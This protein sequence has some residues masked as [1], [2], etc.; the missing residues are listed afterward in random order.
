MSSTTLLVSLEGISLG[1]VE[2]IVQA[3]GID[4]VIVV[5]TGTQ[6][7]DFSSTSTLNNVVAV[8]DAG[9]KVELSVN[10]GSTLSISEEAAEIINTNGFTFVNETS[11]SSFY[12]SLIGT[13]SLISQ[14]ANA[15]FPIF[16][17]DSTEA[18]LTLDSSVIIGEPADDLT[19]TTTYAG[20]RPTYLTDFG[21]TVT[22]NL[23]ADQFS[24]L[25]EETPEVFSTLTSTSSIDVAP[26]ELEPVLPNVPEAFNYLLD[27][28]DVPEN[29]KPFFGNIL[30]VDPTQDT[31][32]PSFDFAFYWSESASFNTL[33]ALS[34]PLQ[35]VLPGAIETPDGVTLSDTAENLIIALPQLSEGQLESFTKILVEGSSPLTLDVE[36]FAKLDTIFFPRNGTSHSGTNLVNA[37]GTDVEINLISNGLSD[38]FDAGLIDEASGE[39]SSSI[40]GSTG[41][42]LIQYIDTLTINNV[43]SDDIATLVELNSIAEFSTDDVVVNFTDHT[44]TADEFIALVGL[45]VDFSNNVSISDAEENLESLLLT[46][47]SDVISAFSYISGLGDPSEPAAL[48]ITYDQYLTLLDGDLDSTIFGN[49]INVELIVS[50]TADELASVFTALGTDFSSL[51]ENVSFRVTDGGEVTLNVAQADKL[52]GRYNG[53]ILISDIGDNISPMLLEAIDTSIKDISVSSGSLQLSVDEFRNLPAYNNDSVTIEDTESNIQ[54]A[55]TYNVLDDRVTKLNVVSES[56]TDPVTVLTLTAAQLENLGDYS[57]E[58]DDIA[59][60]SVVLN[61]RSSAIQEF[62]E[63]GNIPTNVSISFAESSSTDSDIRKVDLNFS[64]S[65]AL[66]HLIIDGKASVPGIEYNAISE[67]FTGLNSNNYFSF[68]SEST[69]S[70]IT[71]IIETVNDIGSNVLYNNYKLDV[72]ENRVEDISYITYE[73]RNTVNDIEDDVANL[74]SDVVALKETEIA[75][76][77]SSVNNLDSDVVALQNDVNDISVT[78]EETRYVTDQI[79]YIT[80]DTRLIADNIRLDVNN[81]DSDVVALKDTEI[82][83]IQDSVNN[84]DSDVVALKESTEIAA[85]QGS[86][87]DLDSDVVALQNDVD[88]I[89]NITEDT[90]DIAAQSLF[91][92]EDTRFIVDNIEQDVNNLDSDVVALKETE[93]A[94]IQGSVNDLDSDVVALQNDVDDISVI[95]EDTRNI[96]A[97]SLFIAEDTRFIVDNIEQDVNNLDSDVVALKE[98]E[99][100]AI[101]GSVNDLDSDVV[102]LIA[103]EITDLQDSVDDLILMSS[104]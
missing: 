95:T 18:E 31:S 45:G 75:A 72:V 102:A 93:I 85:I 71:D 61:D 100:A 22:V 89:S 14:G 23:T 26:T 55:L 94:A 77:Q 90:R 7:D 48:E 39:F 15:P 67:T 66:K 79:R 92:A 56:D 80:D 81:L 49:S 97:Q 28:A 59:V 44:V 27:P 4:R 101:Q 41:Q 35:G 57:I 32:Q 2:E 29:G 65:E 20:E 36:T 42:N 98:T 10:D 87:N 99:I 62:I 68:D 74:D 13:T 52:D 21:G 96:A 16:S 58:I 5:A 12:G 83:A 37:D 51:A 86:V 88:D 53:S 1:G 46:D 103:T 63:S 25:L 38:L 6:F 70:M 50:G 34:L 78:T 43:V 8:K 40:T 73:T 82:A 91:I 54:R 84:L 3:R 47:D 64:E 9:A 30:G 33:Q 76:I 11:L 24:D 104:R 69:D 19:L 17:E 60:S